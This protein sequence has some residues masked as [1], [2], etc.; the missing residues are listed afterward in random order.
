MLKKDRDIN[1]TIW[2]HNST[3]GSFLGVG[4]LTEVS[5]LNISP[6]LE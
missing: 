2:N 5:K 6:T 3:T 4:N 1:K